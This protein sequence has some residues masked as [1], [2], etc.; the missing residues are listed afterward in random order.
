MRTV[1]VNDNVLSKAKKLRRKLW[2]SLIPLSPVFIVVFLDQSPE[3]F[4]QYTGL[5]FWQG[6]S[7]S[8]VFALAGIGYARKIWRCPVC[9]GYLG[10]DILTRFCPHCAT[11]IAIPRS[12]SP[13]STDDEQL[14]RGAALLPVQEFVQVQRDQKK[15]DL[16]RRYRMQIIFSFAITILFA[17]IAILTEV[18]ARRMAGTYAFDVALVQTV[19]LYTAGTFSYCWGAIFLFYLDEA[20]LARFN[21]GFTRILMGIYNIDII[22]VAIT[23]LG[24]V[25]LL[26][27]TVGVFGIWYYFRTRSKLKLVEQAEEKASVTQ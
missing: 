11:Y 12:V 1:Y 2:L 9:S 4:T 3:E 26:F 22:K 23:L 19:V 15:K 7:I 10:S 8:L 16:A 6:L 14:Y 27:V 18:Q 17:G 5:S 21:N 24:G 20:I 13:V 25:L